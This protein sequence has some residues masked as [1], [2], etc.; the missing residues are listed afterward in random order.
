MKGIYL[1]TNYNKIKNIFSTLSEHTKFFSIEKYNQIL[2]LVYDSRE[3]NEKPYI[4]IGK[5]HW[6]CYGWFIYNNEKNN[7][8]KLIK[9]YKNN[10]LKVFGKINAGVFVIVCINNKSIEIFNDA[11]GISTHY[12]SY[13]NNKYYIAPCLKCF[14]NKK[15]NNEL[16]DILKRQGYLFGNYTI[17]RDIKRIDPG[18][19]ISNGEIKK[20]YF[21][22]FSSKMPLENVTK[23]INK[24]CSFWSK[25]NRVIAI[26][27][28]LDS[29]L[30]LASS[31]FMIGFTYGP[32]NSGDRPI[33]RKFKKQFNK[34]LEFSY[35][36]PDRL[37]AE[38]KICDIMFSG[39]TTW[40]YRLLSAY[41]YVE[42]HSNKSHVFFDGYLGDVLQV[43]SYMKFSGIIGGLYKLFPVLYAYKIIPVT[44]ILRNRYSSLT[45]KQQSILIDDFKNRTSFLKTNDEFGKLTYYEFVYGRGG[46]Y[47]INGGNITCSQ[48]FNVVPVFTELNIFHALISKS[49]IRTVRFNNLKYI[50]KNIPKLYKIIKTEYGYKPD[51][52]TWFIPFILFANRIKLHIMSGGDYRREMSNSKKM[53]I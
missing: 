52:T 44:N 3:W 35:K 29:R 24:L 27:G 2:T 6:F 16:N 7:L 15:I 34:Y 49:F 26:S 30:I 14:N 4:I 23:R 37:D 47:I 25:E 17:Y 28:G 21:P 11:L 10:G 53:K 5:E 32:K 50:W 40:V 1:N 9:D 36:K 39:A 22:N 46:R 38:D 42:E 13:F 20:Y 33:A 19:R 48:L 12:F 45:P 51:C 41:K 43:G 8:Y 31:N 18:S